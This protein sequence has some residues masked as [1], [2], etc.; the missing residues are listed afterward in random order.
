MFRT[1][2]IVLKNKHIYSFESFIRRNL[3]Q[4]DRKQMKWSKALII[5]ENMDLIKF[6]CVLI[7]SICAS[8]L[9]SYW[10]FVKF[11]KSKNNNS[12]KEKRKNSLMRFSY[13]SMSRGSPNSDINES[14]NSFSPSTKPNLF[15]EIAEKALPAVVLIRVDQSHVQ[16]PNTVTTNTRGSGFII[17]EDG[18][19]LTCAHIL[20]H[21]KTVSVELNDGRKTDGTVES[22]DEYFDLAIIKID[23]KDLPV[24]EIGDSKQIR[25]GDSVIEIGS[26]FQ[27]LNTITAGVIS[28]LRRH[29][30][31]FGLIPKE[32]HFIQTD[33][34]TDDGSSGGPL[35]DTN[36]RAI[37]INT[38]KRTPGITYAVPSSYAID[39]LERIKA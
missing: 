10:L 21:Y 35:L 17:R 32:V 24:I 6:S 13:N 14:N 23:L 31:S 30:Q 36:G 4:S 18:L 12:S 15:T 3:H 9:L 2:N 11:F 7:G 38:W 27:L 25:P 26:P 39:F 16:Y 22:I 37:G 28:S 20:A 29:G 34:Y 19:I 8:N 33:A 1:N 5:K